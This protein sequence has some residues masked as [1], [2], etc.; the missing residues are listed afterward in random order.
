MNPCTSC[1]FLFSLISILIASGQIRAQ[2]SAKNVSTGLSSESL[3][4][5]SLSACVE[6]KGLE[7]PANNN[8][9]VL[10]NDVLR[11]M[12][13]AKIFPTKIGSTTIEYLDTKAIME[14]YRRVGRKFAVLEVEPLRNVRE[15]LIVNC[16]EYSVNIRRGKLVLG[17]GGGYMVHWRFDCSTGEYAKVKV[18]RWTWRVD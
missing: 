13:S 12:D 6:S 7:S 8:L 15:V 11:G 5:R 2:E 9:V 16:A 4:Q 17:V 10:E 18:E 1:G 14:R 3:Y